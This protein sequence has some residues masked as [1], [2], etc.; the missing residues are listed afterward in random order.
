MT[1]RDHVVLRSVELVCGQEVWIQ[2][3]EVLGC[4]KESNGEL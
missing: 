2:A 1:E 4:C 3:R